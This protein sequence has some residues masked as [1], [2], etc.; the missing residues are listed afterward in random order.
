MRPFQVSDEVIRTGQTKGY[1]NVIFGEKYT[2]RAIR[3]DGFIALVD[4]GFW[5]NPEFFKLVTRTSS[6]FKAFQQR[7]K[8]I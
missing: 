2:I 7:L 8:K 3:G 1:S 5:W 6:G 4:R